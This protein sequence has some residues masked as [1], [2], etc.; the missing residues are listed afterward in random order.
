MR[1]HL[2]RDLLYWIPKHPSIISVLLTMILAKKY[3]VGAYADAG[4]LNPPLWRSASKIICLVMV[5]MT[6]L[7]MVG[8]RKKDR[9]E[10]LQWV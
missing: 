10:D 7:A 2:F 9:P 8:I 1:L 6:A 5:L 4:M 3:A